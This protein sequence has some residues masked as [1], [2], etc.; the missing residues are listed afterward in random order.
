L[1]WTRV[2][3]GVIANVLPDAKL[4][5]AV[6]KDGMLSVFLAKEG[7]EWHLSISHPSRY[8]TWNEIHDARYSLLPNNLTMAMLLP[9]MEEYVNI[10]NNTFHLWQIKGENE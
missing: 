10:H 9:P 6:A 2:K 5:Q 8:P 3:P 4:Y 7:G 1:K